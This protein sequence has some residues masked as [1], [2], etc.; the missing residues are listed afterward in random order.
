MYKK[1]DYRISD[2]TFQKEKLYFYTIVLLFIYFNCKF[3]LISTKTCN[4]IPAHLLEYFHLALE[5][6]F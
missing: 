3:L 5:D 2:L 6:I 4:T 1:E